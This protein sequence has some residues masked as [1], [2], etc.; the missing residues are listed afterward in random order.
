MP[1]WTAP[2]GS[3]NASGELLQVTPAL[4]VSSRGILDAPPARLLTLADLEPRTRASQA[5]AIPRP[6]G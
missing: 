6:E 5:A 2:A 1:T 4:E 3:S